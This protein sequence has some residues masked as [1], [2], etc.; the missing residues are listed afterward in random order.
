VFPRALT[1]AFAWQTAAGMFHLLS[2]AVLAGV[3]AAVVLY[4]R[5]T[6]KTGGVQ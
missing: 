1:R 6:R 3:V 2:V 5:R 4:R